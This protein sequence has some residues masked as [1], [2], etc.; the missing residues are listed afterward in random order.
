MDFLVQWILVIERILIQP[1]FNQTLVFGRWVTPEVV[2]CIAWIS[3]CF[4][5]AFA[6]RIALRGIGCVNR[7]TTV[8]HSHVSFIF[9][10]DVW[11][12]DQAVAV[13]PMQSRLWPSGPYGTSFFVFA[14][15]GRK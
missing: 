11:Q 2:L 1:L 6:V 12:V 10:V 9:V 8:V 4:D 13:G 14:M 3:R 7:V 15:F 5:H